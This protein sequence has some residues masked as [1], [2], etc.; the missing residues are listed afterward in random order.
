MKIALDTIALAKKP[1]G[2]AIEI[3]ARTGYEAVELYSDGWAGRHVP[4]SMTLEE[5]KSLK[6][7]MEDLGLECCA[8]ST[9]IGGRGFNVISEED[10]RRQMEECRRYVA[11]ARVLECPSLRAIAGPKEAGNA[12]RS[13]RLLSKFAE[14][15]PEINFLVEIHFG[16]LIETAEEAA[17]YA[18]L[19]GRDN[20]G[21]IYDPGNMVANDAEFGAK[22]VR[23]LGRRLMHAHIKDVGEVPPG[24]PGS[25]EYGGKTYSWLPMGKG[26]V[27]YKEILGAM[28]EMR[29]DK[30]L[31]VECEGDEKAT[32]EGVEKT[33]AKEKEALEKL[34]TEISGGG[35]SRPAES[36]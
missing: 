34:I 33:I 2:Q 10:V 36:G 18:D 22:D 16:S 13:A 19:V 14:T 29:Y 28:A 20:V 31:S 35:Q 25:F 9:Y 6:A 3:A 24:T 27:K 12:E 17:R 8:I 21:V 23:V 4:S 7:R 26:K 30:Y 5:A 15:D 1:L 32:G 11:I